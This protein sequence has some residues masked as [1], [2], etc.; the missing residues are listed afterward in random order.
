MV[1]ASASNTRVLCDSATV[2]CVSPG[3]VVL[4]VPL[5]VQQQMNPDPLNVFEILVSFKHGP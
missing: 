3:A 4:S 1:F 5:D 2:W